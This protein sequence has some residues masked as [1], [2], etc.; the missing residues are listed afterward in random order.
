MPLSIDF[1][2]KEYEMLQLSGAW[3]RERYMKTRM[4]EQDIQSISSNRG[5]SSHNHNPFLALKRKETD[6][7][8]GQVIGATYVYSGD[9]QAQV[10]VDTYDVNRFQIGM[11]SDNFS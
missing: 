8:T 2:D 1:P 6:E 7:F 9:F 4:L 5:H 11:N 10:E 3:G